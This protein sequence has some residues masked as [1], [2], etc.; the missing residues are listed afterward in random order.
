MGGYLIKYLMYVRLE[1]R[2]LNDEPKAVRA[3]RAT[4]EEKK[5]ARPLALP[6][7]TLKLLRQSFYSGP[8]NLSITPSVRSAFQTLVT[9][10]RVA[11]IAQSPREDGRAH[12]QADPGCRPLRL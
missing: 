11:C 2:A 5:V 10:I 3:R 4:A 8:A 9:H 6:L 1:L 7:Q 12:K